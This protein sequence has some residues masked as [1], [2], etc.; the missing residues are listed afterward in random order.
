[1]SGKGSKGM[2]GGLVVPGFGAGGL[3]TPSLTPSASSS[4]ARSK[5]ASVM[6]YDVLIK[7]SRVGVGAS[8]ADVVVLSQLVQRTKVS[9]CVVADT[10]LLGALRTLKVV[11]EVRV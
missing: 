10:Y 5:L 6:S 9:H 1:M 7:L 3:H 4:L 11:P 2:G 8:V